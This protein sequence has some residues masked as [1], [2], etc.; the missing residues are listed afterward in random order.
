MKNFEDSAFV[1]EVHN[2]EGDHDTAYSLCEVCGEF[3]EN[4]KHPHTYW[5][6]KDYAG[7]VCGLTRT[8]LVHQMT[9]I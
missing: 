5:P 7:C 1:S 3:K 2:F 4:T 9:K 8:A 6:A